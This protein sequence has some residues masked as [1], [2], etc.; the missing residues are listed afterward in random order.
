MYLVR[1]SKIV[2]LGVVIELN[3]SFLWPVEHVRRNSNHSRYFIKYVVESE[4]T[5]ELIDDPD[6]V[7]TYHCLR[8]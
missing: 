4:K 2:W 7:V 3:S 5:N 8:E 1:I 6:R